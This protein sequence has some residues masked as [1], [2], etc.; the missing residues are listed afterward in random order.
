MHCAHYS[1]TSLLRLVLTQVDVPTLSFES[2]ADWEL[3]QSSVAALGADLRVNPALLPPAAAPVRSFTSSL[4]QNYALL[5]PRRRSFG[6]E[7]E[8][9]ESGH[10]TSP[11]A[12]SSSSSMTSTTSLDVTRTAKEVVANLNAAM[13]RHSCYLERMLLSPSF[14]TR[15][16]DETLLKPLQFMAGVLAG[17]VVGVTLTK[18]LL[19]AP[20]DAGTSPNLVSK[21]AK[22]CSQRAAASDGTPMHL[23]PFPM[24]DY[25]YLMHPA[26]V[27]VA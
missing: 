6:D 1:I 13:T 27:E 22:W 8:F 18:Q 10:A 11:S 12:A 21:L 20:Q 3:L 19:R 26:A 9:E 25:S 16:S 7:A 2:I 14:S 17:V 4:V 5:S 15:W 24:D 23:M